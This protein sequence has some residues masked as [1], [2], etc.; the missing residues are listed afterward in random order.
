M[1]DA[2]SQSTQHA[3]AVAWLERGPLMV[4]PETDA[5]IG[6]A[7][8]AGAS[9]RHRRGRA[10]GLQAVIRSLH[11]RFSLLSAGLAEAGAQGR[12]VEQSPARE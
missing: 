2:Y 6:A 1:C 5:D 3:R 7:G 10:G 12:S 8:D 9:P 11:H 4:W